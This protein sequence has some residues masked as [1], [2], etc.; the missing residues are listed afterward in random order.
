MY[1]YVPKAYLGIYD[2]GVYKKLVS[3]IFNLLD[4]ESIYVEAVSKN[5]EVLQISL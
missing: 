4:Y 5:R 3:S 2:C 1:K